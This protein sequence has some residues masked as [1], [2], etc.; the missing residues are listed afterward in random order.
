MFSSCTISD[1]GRYNRVQSISIQCTKFNVL[2][3][4]S[5]DVPQIENSIANL[6]LHSIIVKYNR[7]CYLVGKCS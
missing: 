5:V 2:Y 4:I 7:L 3:I 1:S 6:R